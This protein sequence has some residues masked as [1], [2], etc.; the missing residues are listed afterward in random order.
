MLQENLVIDALSQNIKT[1]TVSWI[2]PRHKARSALEHFIHQNYLRVHQAEINHFFDHLF[3]CSDGENF[4]ASLGINFLKDTQHAFVEQY[5][6]D[7]AEKVI[8]ILLNQSIS[9]DEIVELGN[10]SS[11][12]AGATRRMIH[13]IS[14]QLITKGVRWAIFTI[15]KSVLN[16]FIKS[17]LNPIF[18]TAAEKTKLIDQ[19]TNWGNYYKTNPGVYV[20]RIPN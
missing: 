10:L 7:S 17:G 1:C 4:M 9:R 8:S 5:L 19:S 13:K 20:V 12:M 15:N 3:A 16:A 11:V 14:P 2:D 6:N 18:I